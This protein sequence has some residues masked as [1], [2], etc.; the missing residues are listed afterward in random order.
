MSGLLTHG[1]VVHERLAAILAGFA[2][3]PERRIHK[4]L[5]PRKRIHIVSVV[6]RHGILRAE[7]H[8]NGKQHQNDDDDRP[9]NRS[10]VFAEARKGILHIGAG[11]GL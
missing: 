2:A 1:I 9:Y 3:V 5:V 11:L 8:D 4:P 10:F 7:W 6:I